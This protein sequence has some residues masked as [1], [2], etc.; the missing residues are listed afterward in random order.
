MYPI[1]PT[2]SFIVD[3]L[4]CPTTPRAKTPLTCRSVREQE[5][6]STALRRENFKLKLRIYFMEQNASNQKNPTNAT[7]ATPSATSD[8]QQQQSEEIVTLRI[9]NELL[10]N[11]LFEK[12]GLICE[13]AEGMEQMDE[14]LR[15]ERSQH[16]DLVDRMQTEID[17]LQTK[18]ADMTACAMRSSMDA[19]RRSK[20]DHQQRRL[21]DLEMEL[22]EKRDALKVLTD[23]LAGTDD[24][25]AEAKQRYCELETAHNR[26]I[27]ELDSLKEELAEKTTHNNEL[28][29]FRAYSKKNFVQHMDVLRSENRTLR[30]EMMHMKR[31]MHGRDSAES[32]LDENLRII[33]DQ[34]RL[35]RGLHVSIG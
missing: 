32:S 8:P 11:E 10:R 22:T 1:H 13:A 33:A 15:N 6:H 27:F 9:D 7:V 34:D 12:Q 5:E 14:L 24:R 18:V 29:M 16:D 23:K 21:A 26:A 3:D 28:E 4:D 20:D 17:Q 2:I 25:M 30:E 35:M 31:Q 19:M